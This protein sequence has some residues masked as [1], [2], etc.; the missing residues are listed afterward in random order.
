[1]ALKPAKKGSNMAHFE[2]N[3]NLN[4]PNRKDRVGLCGSSLEYPVQ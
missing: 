1:M 3:S 2:T 4:T